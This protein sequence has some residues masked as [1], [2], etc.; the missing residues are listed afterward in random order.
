[1]KSNEKNRDI[2]KGTLYICAT[3]I[4]NLKDITLR[5]LEHLKEADFIAVESIN[6]SRKL[7]HHY[8]IKSPLISFRES[9][10]DKK[11]VEILQKLKEGAKIALISDAGMPLISDPGRYL[12]NL[13]LEEGIPYTVL[14]GPSAVLTALTISGYSGDRFVFWGFLSRDRAT[15]KKELESIAGE[16][17][18]VVAFESPHR[19]V[20]TLEEAKEIL[21]EREIAVCRELTKKFEE[22]RRG[23]AALL[24]DHFLNTPPRGEITLVIAPQREK[25]GVRG[26]GKKTSV[27]L[28]LL[29]E[30]CK[31]LL[32]LSVKE[33]IP[34]SEAVK[35]VARDTSL[36]K[37]E[38]YTIL[39][40]LKRKGLIKH[41]K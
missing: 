32:L 21:K 7:L 35:K 15:M 4:G 8:G 12:L 19:L 36:S 18:A 22:V 14:P 16:E 6:H 23:S 9:N 27:E 10:R 39:V 11:S 1:M 20:K 38:V 30:E 2:I 3:P 25:T 28:E 40:Q 29:K 31:H 17:K 33:G 5:A 41:N 26:K 37:N 24:L 13:L 34:P